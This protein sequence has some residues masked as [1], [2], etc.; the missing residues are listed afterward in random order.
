MRRLI[1]ATAI[2][3]LASQNAIAGWPWSTCDED[4]YRTATLRALKSAGLYPIDVGGCDWLETCTDGNIAAARKRATDIREFAS[5]LSDDCAKAAYLRWA[6]FVD[7]QADKGE[8]EMKTHETRNKY[9]G[10]E[11]KFRE[12]D[13]KAAE[14]GRD[15][16]TPSQRQ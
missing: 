10:I 14:I 1:L 11:A 12:N 8:R 6:R 13:R 2:A 3:T 9:D 5:T 16:P 7:Y 15:L 4:A